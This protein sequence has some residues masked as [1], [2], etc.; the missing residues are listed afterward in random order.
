MQEH[1][2]LRGRWCAD[3]APCVRQNIYIIPLHCKKE[4]TN[5][6][7]WYPPCL[8]H[9]QNHKAVELWEIS[10]LP[11]VCHL[12]HSTQVGHPHLDKWLWGQLRKSPPAAAVVVRCSI[13][14]GAGVWAAWYL[15]KCRWGCKVLL[16]ME[17][18]IAEARAAPCYLFPVI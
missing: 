6:L 8:A 5:T 7:T 4:N 12:S 11:A 10:W 2:C 15:E 18:S 13:R 14:L 1:Q 16:E 17:P 3:S 9:V